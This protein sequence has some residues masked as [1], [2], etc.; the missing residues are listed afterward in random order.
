MSVLDRK[1]LREL[2]HMRGQAL[3]I[4]LVMACGVATFVMSFCTIDSLHLT[5]QTFFERFRFADLFVHLKRA[6]QTLLEPLREIPGIAQLEPRIVMEVSLDVPGMAEPAVGR[7]NS[8]PDRREPLLNRL[9]LRRGRN[10]EP[11]RPGEVL[12][13]ESFAQAHELAPGHTLA[14]VINGKKE[15]LTVVGIVLS[16]EYV[17]PV[18]PGEF[19][20]DSRRYGIFWMGYS[21]LA[22]AFDMEG[23]FNDVAFSLLPGT[24]EAEVIKKV[25]RLTFDYGGTGAYGRADQLSYRFISNEMNQLRTMASLPPI[26]FLSVTAFLL[27]VVLSRLIGIQ[28][29]QI[30]MLKAFGYSS[31]ETGWHYFKLVLLLVVIGMI[32]GVSMGAWLGYSLTQVYT[33]FFRFP[34]FYFHLSPGVVLASL[35]VSLLASGAGTALAVWSAI[36]LPVAEAMRPEAPAVYHATLLEKFGLQGWLSPALQM[37]LRNLERQPLK[38]VLACLGIA[39]SIAIV[40]MGNCARDAV[41]EMM[42]LAFKT[43]QRQDMTI[44]FI[45]PTSNRVMHDLMHLPGVL[46]SEAFRSVPARLR[47]QHRSRRLAI[48]GLGD[49]RQL[50]R[51]LNLQGREVPIPQNGLVISAKLAE[52]FDC[53]VG[54]WLEVDILEGERP[55][56]SLK[57][58]AL[59]DD[60]TEPAAYMHKD[61]LHRMMREGES[62]S[63]A[64][65][66]VDQQHVDQLYREMKSMPRIAGINLKQKMIDT[67]QQLLDENLLMM[68][69]F[70]VFFASVIAFGVVYNNARI[71]L[72]ERSRELATLRVMGFTRSEISTMFL[73][74]L[75]VITL[76]AIPLGLLLGYLL[77][78]LMM[79]ALDTETQRFPLVIH[80]S[81]Y[82]LAITITVIATG[83]SAW[84]VSYRLN[85]LD[86]VAVLKA[87]E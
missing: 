72:S 9:Y 34:I 21:Q 39:L 68:I 75:A 28:R 52:I 54:E 66:Q 18:R 24:I 78:W 10:I 51:L 63:G 5:E 47:F 62:S 79:T 27:H 46:R 7:I 4:C 16:P 40:V 56:R 26:I 64:F 69:L 44:A 11:D 48:L 59:L 55:T 2:Y 8:T 32:L 49:D 33:H 50:Y 25:D 67:F 77:A 20:P 84:L 83:I 74:E 43:A 86:L 15:K 14:A 73:G 82:A 53:R 29:E 42:E 41:G 35:G 37:I 60:F 70:N 22:A 61:A 65:L 12:V 85:R 87:R 23:A 36:R 38:T 1:L 45:E 6:P 30:A 3:A 31:W 17:Y 76:L 13:H 71:S 81:T 58:V 19:V 80:A 57:L